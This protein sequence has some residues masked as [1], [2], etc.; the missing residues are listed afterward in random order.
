M[1]YIHVN[2]ISFVD[3]TE[4]V[5]YFS[6]KVESYLQNEQ[7]QAAIKIQKR[8]R[9]FQERERLTGRRSHVHKSRAAVKIQR[10]FR[11]WLERQERRKGDVPSHLRPPGLTDDRRVELQKVISNHREEN[12]VCTWQLWRFFFFII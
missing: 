5:R 4:T 11:T 7:I 6:A 10:F 8:W 12:P 3:F 1:H 9:G 2:Q